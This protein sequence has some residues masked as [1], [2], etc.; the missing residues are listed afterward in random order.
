[1]PSKLKTKLEN[2][3]YHIL[4]QRGAYKACQW[5]K[6]SLL[7]GD[8]CYKQRFYGIESHRCLQMTP[9]VD[10]CTQNC[11]FCWRVIPS[12]IDC[13]WDQTH[14]SGDDVLSPEE[15]LDATLMAN[16]R[17][18][19]GYNP[20]IEPRVTKR[21]Y[22]K[23][24]DPK[25]VAISLAGEP[26]LYPFLS[27]FIEEIDRRRMTSFLVTNGTRPDV[28]AE[29]TL[30]TQLYITLAAPSAEIQKK[31]LRPSIPKAWDLLNESQELLQSL[32]CRKVNRLTMVAERN[33]QDPR[34][35]SRMILKGEPDFVEVKGYMFLGSSR[36]RLNRSNAPSHREI[37]AFSEKLAALTGY[38]LLDE[39]VESRV[40]LLS[41]TKQ[42][43]RL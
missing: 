15:L 43:K 10:K 31:L 1:M 22:E 11:D 24:R 3:G 9:V 19:G 41:R 25:H 20:D 32:N 7:H 30:P 38:Y 33:M 21:M 23:A 29:I 39:Q 17:S 5:Q 42:I 18:L 12:D 16:L 8:V 4:G 34:G 36:G 37:R 26:T 2:Q 40:T 6:K 27:E 35:F 13:A 14:V 28:L